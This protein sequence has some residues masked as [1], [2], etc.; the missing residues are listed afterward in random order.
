[1]V[2]FTPVI[3]PD[4]P[5]AFL[6]KHPDHPPTKKSLKIPFMTG[7]VADEGLIKSPGQQIIQ[8]LPKRL[9]KTIFIL[10][11]LIL[12]MLD[13][14]GLFEKFVEKMD[15]AL[16]Y[17]FYYDHHDLSVQKS[18]T[19]KLKKFYFDNNLTRDKVANFTN[20]WFGF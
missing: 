17:I 3:E 14:P 16:P 10:L 11:I 6:T 5:G 7:L 4:L 18:I 20:V 15:Y 13:T 19:K 2:P 1:M 12:A 9:T 8:I